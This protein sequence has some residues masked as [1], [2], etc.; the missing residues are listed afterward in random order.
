MQ[1]AYE[2]QDYHG[3]TSMITACWGVYSLS[4]TGSADEWK[5]AVLTMTEGISSLR[6]ERGEAGSIR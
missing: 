2:L 6:P 1:Q 4:T 3:I 5:Q